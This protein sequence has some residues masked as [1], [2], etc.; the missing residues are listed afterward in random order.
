M[1][2]SSLNFFHKDHFLTVMFQAQGIPG[3]ELTFFGVPYEALLNGYK[4]LNQ[5]HQVLLNLEVGGMGWFFC[6]K[7]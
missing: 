5:V 3:F 2:G 6:N 1:L 7:V 4:V